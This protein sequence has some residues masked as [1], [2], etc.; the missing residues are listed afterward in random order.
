MV[1][2]RR[3]APLVGLL[4]L[5]ACGDDLETRNA[6]IAEGAPPRPVTV[7]TTVTRPSRTAQQSAPGFADEDEAPTRRRSSS[8]GEGEDPLIV[9]AD[10]DS[11]V[12]DAQ[13]FAP[14]PLDDAVGLAPTPMQEPDPGE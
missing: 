13:G 8:I 2:A 9:D 11:L 12:D 10:P 7:E 4:A 14:E 5:A 6:A 1:S 3:L